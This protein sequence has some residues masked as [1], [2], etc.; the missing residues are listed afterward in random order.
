MEEQLSARD[1]AIQTNLVEC[2][3]CVPMISAPYST[4]NITMMSAD[5]DDDDDDDADAD[6]NGT[7]ARGGL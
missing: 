6:G 1:T 3:E 5:D 7:R 2:V 4:E